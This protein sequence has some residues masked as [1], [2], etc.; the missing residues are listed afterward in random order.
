MLFS[1]MFPI[2]FRILTH[3]AHSTMSSVR[4]SLALVNVWH[5]T[6]TLVLTT[7]AAAPPKRTILLSHDLFDNFASIRTIPALSTLLLYTLK[8]HQDSHSFSFAVASALIRFFLQWDICQ[9]T[10]LQ[11]RSSAPAISSFPTSATIWP[12]YLTIVLARA[13]AELPT[14][15]KFLL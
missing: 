12:F 1:I 3:C 13:V 5:T 7:S 9:L 10:A 4:F 15:A 2:S 11:L 14:C 6:H 8:Q